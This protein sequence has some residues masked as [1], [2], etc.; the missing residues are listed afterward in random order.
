MKVVTLS[1]ILYT[2]QIF[3][4]CHWNLKSL[5]V[6]NF[7]IVNLLPAYNSIHSFDIICLS[8]TFLDSTFQL[9]HPNLL[10]NNYTL[11]RNDHPDN[12]KRGGVSIY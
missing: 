11:V 6:H 1:L 4:I 9:D 2:S 7:S 8:E 10:M 5:A 12:V 3:S